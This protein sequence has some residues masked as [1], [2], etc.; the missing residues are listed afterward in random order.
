MLPPFAVM[1]PRTLLPSFLLL[2]SGLPAL[3]AEE[4]YTFRRPAMG[5]VWTIKLYAESEKVADEAAAAAFARVEEIN[6]A[7]SD[8]LPDS[9]LSRLSASAGQGK[10]VTVTGDLRA[11]L[12]RSLDASRKSGGAFDLTV[13]PCVLLWR[14]SRKTRRL[15]EPAALAAAL[16]SS[17]WES[18]TFDADAGA[19]LLKK[20]GMRLDAGGIAKGYAQDEAM[21]VLRERCGIQSALID[22]GSPLVSGRPPGR[23]GWNIALAKVE[24]DEPETVLQVEN[25]CVDTSGDL[26]QAVE[27][28]GRRYSHIIDPKTGLGLTASVQATVVAP[29][30]TDADWL[31]T[32][33]CV[34]G[35]EQGMTFMARHYPKLQARIAQRNSDGSL[36]RAQTHGFAALLKPE[37]A[38][39]EG[40]KAPALPAAK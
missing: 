5:T 6:Q 21:K 24:P 34:M 4:A 23:A 12:E 40:Q 27:I 3:R 37:T 33:L 16:Q 38:N 11:V 32:A 28:D 35:P 20:P 26:H 17:G 15:P 22:C 1:L 30:A 8:Y 31:A 36:V 25:L 10:P 9:A 39:P 14:E 18:L 29:S 7:L 2:I 19:A 13:G